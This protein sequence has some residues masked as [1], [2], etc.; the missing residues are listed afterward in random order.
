[1]YLTATLE[2]GVWSCVLVVSW[3]LEM[4]PDVVVDCLLET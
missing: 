2:F 3:R 4:W 1:M